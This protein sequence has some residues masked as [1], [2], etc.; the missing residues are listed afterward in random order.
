[1]IFVNLA[2]IKKTAAQVY[3]YFS[4][5][6]KVYSQRKI[7]KEELNRHKQLWW[8]ALVLL[9]CEESM[10]CKVKKDERN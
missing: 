4:H 6:N 5:K 10:I 7:N 3:H 9:Q 2:N 1:M 8:H